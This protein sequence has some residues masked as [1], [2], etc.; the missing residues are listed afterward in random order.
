MIFK[1][2]FKIWLWRWQK[3][4]MASIWRISCSCLVI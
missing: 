2:F 4:R 1:Q 3:R